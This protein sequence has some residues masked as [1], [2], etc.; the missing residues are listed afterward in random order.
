MGIEAYLEGIQGE[1]YY[2]TVEDYSGEPWS[3]ALRFGG[4]GDGTLF[5]PAHPMRIGGKTEIPVASLRLEALREG[6][7]TMRC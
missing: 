1:L 7:R 5:Y 3:D 4:N 2:N 6:L